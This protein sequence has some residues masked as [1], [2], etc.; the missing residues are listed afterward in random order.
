MLA[1]ELAG[2]I[3]SGNEFHYINNTITKNVL[4]R[5]ETMGNLRNLNR[6]PEV[7][8]YGERLKNMK[9]QNCIALF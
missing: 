1:I 2:T 6:F 8:G 4:F 3:L 9:T 7:Q 5:T